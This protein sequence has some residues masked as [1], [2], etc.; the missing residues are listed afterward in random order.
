MSYTS[1]INQ[2]VF[3]SSLTTLFSSL[4]LSVLNTL[5]GIHRVKTFLCVCDPAGQLLLV[6]CRRE[7]NTE[8]GLE[9]RR[10]EMLT[11]A[12]AHAT[13]AC[14]HENTHTLFKIKVMALTV[15]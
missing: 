14:I 11:R 9:N 10:E 5:S 7:Q 15:P 6:L 12:H 2:Y 1:Y 8:E 13:N 3:F 4:V